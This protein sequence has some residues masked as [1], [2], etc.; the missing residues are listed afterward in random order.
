M[1]HI[2]LPMILLATRI[3]KYQKLYELSSNALPEIVILYTLPIFH[4]AQDLE[5]YVIKRKC[6]KEPFGLLNDL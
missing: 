1:T 4:R 2:L 5:S 6:C 3:D